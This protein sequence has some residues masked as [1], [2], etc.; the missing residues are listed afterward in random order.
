MMTNKII[1]FLDQLPWTYKGI[2]IAMLVWA[3][4]SMAVS[5]HTKPHKS[6]LAG[7]SFPNLPE[8]IAKDREMIYI[9]DR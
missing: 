4:I 2:V 5:M 9:F 8:E 1:N 3:F 6:A 7:K